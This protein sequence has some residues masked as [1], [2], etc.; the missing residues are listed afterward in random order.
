[1]SDDPNGLPRGVKHIGQMFSFK[2]EDLGP[3]MRSAYDAYHRVFDK[4]PEDKMLVIRQMLMAFVAASEAYQSLFKYSG[5]MRTDTQRICE[6]AGG[7]SRWLIHMANIRQIAKGGNDVVLPMMDKT[8]E[9]L[10]ERGWYGLPK[11]INENGIRII[12]TA[13]GIN[14]DMVSYYDAY[15]K[16]MFRL[17]YGVGDDLGGKKGQPNANAIGRR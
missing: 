9:W 7:A 8:S 3:T 15:N 2:R 11:P 6:V 14:D 1:M 5:D 17:G 16:L 10:I 13:A 4:I 12:K